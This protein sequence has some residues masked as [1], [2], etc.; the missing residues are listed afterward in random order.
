MAKRDAVFPAGRRALYEIN[1]YSAA[2]RAGDFL[3]VSG[4]VGSLED[5]SPEPDFEKQVQLAFDNLAAVLKAAGCTFDDVV[6]DE[7]VSGGGRGAPPDGPMRDRR[8]VA[9][10]FAGFPGTP[11]G[12]ALARRR[13]ALR[14]IR[15]TSQTGLNRLSAVRYLSASLVRPLGDWG[16]PAGPDPPTRFRPSEA[17]GRGVHWQVD[18]RESCCL[19]LFAPRSSWAPS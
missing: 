11:V 12:A 9:I 16:R 7:P 1:R 3:F 18:R 8:G 13:R 15:W 10:A 4:Q 5:G 19:G 6:E 2:I 14:V 17:V